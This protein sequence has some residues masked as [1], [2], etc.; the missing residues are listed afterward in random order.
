MDWIDNL[1]EQTGSEITFEYFKE[2]YPAYDSFWYDKIKSCD[3]FEMLEKQHYKASVCYAI[4]SIYILKG[5]WIEKESI[6]ALDATSS[7]CYAIGVIEGRWEEGEPAIMK[8]SY[9]SFNYAR[10]VIKGR[11]EEAEHV[12]AKGSDP[13]ERYM[14]FL[15]E[16][17]N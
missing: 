1:V 3:S 15:S 6:I 14:K 8:N 16:L 17:E 4:Y 13:W 2:T 10:G 9:E 12:I 5:R 11:W 7:V